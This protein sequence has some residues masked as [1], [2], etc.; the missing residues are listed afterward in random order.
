MPSQVTFETVAPT[1]ADQGEPE[2]IEPK[3]FIVARLG[4]RSNAVL[5]IEVTVEGKVIEVNFVD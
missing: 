5:V 1:G 2:G 4:F 3:K